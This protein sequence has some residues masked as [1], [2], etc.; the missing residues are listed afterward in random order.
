MEDNLGICEKIYKG[1]DSKAF[2]ESQETINNNIVFT[3][4]IEMIPKL[5]QLGVDIPIEVILQQLK[6]L[7]DAY[8][9]RDSMLLADT[10]RYEINDSLQVYLEILEQLEKENIM[11]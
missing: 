11:L 3:E 10:L 2:S 4:F 5:Q 8:E 9:Y 1:E 6:N 7:V